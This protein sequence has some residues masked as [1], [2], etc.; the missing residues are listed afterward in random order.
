[1]DIKE[2]LRLAAR[3]AENEQLSLIPPDSEIEWV[4]SEEFIAKIDEIAEP[5]PKRRLFTIRRAVTAAA[6]IAL[7]STMFIPV[8]MSPDT[9]DGT[10]GDGGNLFYGSD[11]A[12]DDKALGEQL[13]GDIPTTESK[14]DSGT[15]ESED[16]FGTLE[17]EDNFGTPESKDDS[18]TP[19]SEAESRP[20]STPNPDDYDGV[21]DAE[22]IPVEVVFEPDYLPEGYVQTDL[23]ISQRFTVMTYSNG[24][25]VI[26]LYCIDGTSDF[27][28]YEEVKINI[29]QI[30][31][32][33]NA[34]TDS[35]NYNP[36]GIENNQQN[37]SWNGSNV[38]FVLTGNE[39]IS[40]EE[41]IKIAASVNIEPKE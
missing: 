39:N 23:T 33:N 28:A 10:N 31:Y 9:S 12:S 24:N 4:P 14:D 29:N 27:S 13:K 36:D 3:Q 38:T 11:A 8:F 20:P 30:D 17:S 41:L 15:P 40:Q 18:G 1:M 35:F 2:K 37:V 7:I 16:N 5:K 22:D 19:E 34:P 21:S 26:R 32:Y 6:V 25:S